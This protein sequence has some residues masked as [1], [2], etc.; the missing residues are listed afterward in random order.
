MKLTKKILTTLKNYATINPGIIFKPGSVIRTISIEQNIYAECD[1]GVEFPVE[2]CIFDLGEFLSTVSIFNDADLE[3]SDEYVTISE[4]KSSVRYY[5]SSPMVVTGVTNVPTFESGD[6]QFSLTQPEMSSL[7]KASSILDLDTLNVTA[8]EG[9]VLLS[10][11]NSDNCTS[12]KFT[13]HVDTDT[14]GELGDSI[15]IDNLK[16]LSMDYDVEIVSEEFIH[17][18]NPTEGVRYWVTVD[19]D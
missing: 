16:M 2:F 1:I 8:D 13:H 10:V 14:T 3:F 5:Y 12:N 19:A 15:S 6:T 11:T 7:L 17:F 4:G 9:G 18:N